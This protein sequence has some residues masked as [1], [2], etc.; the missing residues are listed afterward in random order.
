M[1]RTRFRYVAGPGERAF[2]AAGRVASRGRGGD[3]TGMAR[4]PG[5]VSGVRGRLAAVGGCREGLGGV[6]AGLSPPART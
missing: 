2:P 5:A 1:A 4:P 3:E 6:G